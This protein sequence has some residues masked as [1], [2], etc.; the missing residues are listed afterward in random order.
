MV[1]FAPAGDEDFELVGNTILKGKRVGA[2]S[3]VLVKPSDGYAFRPLMVFDIRDY[4]LVKGPEG[5]FMVVK[6]FPPM[7]MPV[8]AKFAV[9]NSFDQD[10]VNIIQAALNDLKF[11]E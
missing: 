11:Q 2:A 4:K 5:Q 8:E 3:G 9:S 6:Q 1:R 7:E 10:V